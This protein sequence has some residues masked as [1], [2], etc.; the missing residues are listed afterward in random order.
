MNAAPSAAGAGYY[1]RP[2]LK[3][4]VW[5]WEIPAYFF[6]GGLAGASATLA[7]GARA[8]G[9]PALR[10]GAAAAAA[11]AAALSPPLL[12]ADLGRP[13]RFANMWRVAKI[14]SPM[15][16]G[17]WVLTAFAPA[18]VGAAVCEWRGRLPRSARLLEVVAG[19]LGPV[20]A[21]YTAVL[22]ADTAVPAWHGARRQLPL[23]FASTAA[24]SAGAAAA[25]LTPACAAAPA[26]RLVVLGVS[27]AVA[28]SRAMDRTLGAQAVHHRSPEATAATVALVAG[29]G[30]VAFAGCRP[31]RRV[32]GVVG[33]ALTLVGA[34]LERVAVTQA[35]RRSA[36]ASR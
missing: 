11:V 19:G 4:P 35:G 27:G 31:R 5:K 36:L 21:T 15:S 18:A 2:V 1:G 33:A 23:V 14:T 9:N 22:L 32:V 30:A 24:A 28:A 29:A 10:R 12:I 34:A 17:T 6:T 26:R 8:T 16:V 3:A 20:M 25:L 7:L 13:A